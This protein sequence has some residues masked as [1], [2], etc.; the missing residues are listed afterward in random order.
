M[1]RHSSNE[2]LSLSEACFKT[3]TSP[4]LPFTIELVPLEVCKKTSCWHSLFLNAVVTGGFNTPKRT[5]GR[6]LEISFGDM[7]GLSRTLRL[8]EYNKGTVAEGPQNL[9]I[10]IK[11]LHDDG[12]IQWHLEERWSTDTM[13]GTRRKATT[14]EILSKIPSRPCL[15]NLD[16]E[17]L[18]TQRNFLGWTDSAQICLGTSPISNAMDF[19]SS[20]VSGPRHERTRVTSYNFGLGFS[21]WGGATFGATA[22]TAFIQNRFSRTARK[23][24][25][26]TL[27]DSEK[28]SIVLYD[29]NEKTAWHCPKLSVMLYMFQIS[30]KL[31]NIRAYRTDSE[32]QVLIPT[33]PRSADGSQAALKTIRD[34]FEIKLEKGGKYEG[35]FADYI[36]SLCLSL[37][38]GQ[39][40]AIEAWENAV[41]HGKAAPKGIVGFEVMEI[42]KEQSVLNVKEEKVDQ[43]WAHIAQDGGL[44][45]FVK[46]LGQAIIPSNPESLCEDWQRVP[47]GRNYLAAGSS[48]LSYLLMDYARSRLSDQLS[49]DFKHPTSHSDN[50]RVSRCKRVQFLRSAEKRIHQPGLWNAL[51][52]YNNGAFVFDHQLSS[53]ERAFALMRLKTE[54]KVRIPH[55][56]D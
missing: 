21:H 56:S 32:S 52:Q 5:E 20:G 53:W 37:D 1:I 15:D 35:K 23:N 19:S 9:L 31:R 43:P 33:A 25:D 44:V 28:E 11:R 3:S 6:G 51:C 38:L 4:K 34:S 16:L 2:L 13:K 41:K 40:R 14:A 50:C 39:Q 8:V 36:E 12:G 54:H 26:D 46:D 7:V 30:C 45:L 24:L 47:P 18:K 49:W 55:R 42:I 29:S 10:P 22:T 17:A 27:Q 48:G